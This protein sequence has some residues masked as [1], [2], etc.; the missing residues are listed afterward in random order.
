MSAKR[1]LF[2]VF[3]S[4]SSRD[5]QW[6][7]GWLLQRLEDAGLKVCVDFK[8]F[9]PGAPLITEMER[10][11]Q[12]SRKTLLVLSKEYLSSEWCEFESLMTQTLDPGARQR[13]VI[14]LILKKC[15]LPNRIEMLTPIWFTAAADE[16][17]SLHRLLQVLR[18]RHAATRTKKKTGIISE[19]PSGTLLPDSPVYVA[20]RDDPKVKAQ[21]PG[22]GTT[23][24]VRGAWQMGK[25]SLLAR[26]IVH[27][28]EQGCIVLDFDFQDVDSHYFSS[29]NTLLRYLADSMCERLNPDVAPDH[30]WS[31]PRF[32][33]KDKIRSYLENEILSSGDPVL[34]VID[35][36]DRVIGKKYQAD[37][38]G[39]LR[40]WH[41]RRATNPVWRQFNLLMSISTAPHQMIRVPTQSPFNVGVKVRLEGFTL[42]ELWE[43]NRLHGR[44]VRQ[45]DQ[46]KRIR[47]FIG[48]H[49]YLAQRTLYSIASGE[50][51]IEQLLDVDHVAPG[52]F[53]DHLQQLLSHLEKH[54]ELKQAFRQ[55]MDKGSCPHVDRFWRLRSLGLV[56]G[57]N[58]QSVKPACRLYEHFFGGFLT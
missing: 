7:R 48:G 49:P 32:G 24:T 56:V 3:V 42:D 26:G 13:R 44:P 23:T 35:E 55:V 21:A 17:L 20:R 10:C 29:L 25:S 54:R 31:S 9:E 38:F 1:Y 5:K 12:R 16:K 33:A 22:S 15:E 30:V 52:P 46:I 34:L 14:P 58:P 40:A 37:F 27:A 47:D 50:G 45:K 4:Y 19:V 43:L 57:A 11:V 28:R 18:A 36:A 6:V 51:T 2:D 8:S 53:E 41:N 39:M